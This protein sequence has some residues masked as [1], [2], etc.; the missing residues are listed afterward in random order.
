MIAQAILIQRAKLIIYQY[1]AHG[2]HNGIR[3]GLFLLIF[4]L[5][6]LILNVLFCIVILFNGFLFGKYGKKINRITESQ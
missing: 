1:E 6:K 5:Q 4:Q 3:L 2:I